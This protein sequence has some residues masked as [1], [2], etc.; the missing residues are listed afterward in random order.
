[1]DQVS[2]FSMVDINKDERFLCIVKDDKIMNLSYEEIFNADLYD[3]LYAITYVSSPSFF[4]KVV[5]DF[6]RVKIVLGID[7]PELLENF[8]NGLSEL[9][10]IKKRTNFWNELNTDIKEKM[11]DD[12]I[13]IRFYSKNPIHSKIYLL[14]NSETKNNRVIIGSANLTEAAFA[15]KNQYEDIIIFDNDEKKFD[16]YFNYRFKNIFENSI[17]YIPEKVRK[18][19]IK[20]STVVLLDKETAT[21]LLNADLENNRLK[22][23][24][25][26]EKQIEKL[27]NRPQEIVEKF[28]LKKDEVVRSTS[29][30]N[31]VIKKKGYSYT[32]KPFVEL[33]KQKVH[34]ETLISKTSK[35]EEEEIRQFYKYWDKLDTII[36]VDK[37]N[38]DNYIPF[39]EKADINK[40]SK[41]LI[42]INKFIDA[43]KQFTFKP[44]IIY[45]S[46]IMEAILFSF[47]SPFMWK[48][49]EDIV[50]R[51]NAESN[52]STFPIILVLAGRAAS[53]K[54][55]VLEFIGMLL[56]N[57]SPFYIPYTSIQKGKTV[58]KNIMEGYFATEN[59]SPVLV[60]EI[61]PSFFTGRTGE[62]IIKD[63]SNNANGKHPVL[64]CTTNAREFNTNGQVLRRIY[65]IQVDSEFNLKELSTESKQY[66]NEI[67]SEIDC[68]LFKD[69]TYRVCQKIK[70]NEDYYR[71]NDCLYLARE[72]FKDYYNESNIEVPEWFPKQPFFDYEERGKTIWREL[73][74]N[75]K[76]SFKDKGDGT[77]YVDG[78]IFK[79]PKEKENCVNFLGYGCLKED[80]QIL[81]LDSDIFYKY[82]GV[83]PRKSIG[84]ILKRALKI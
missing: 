7:D 15:S 44:N 79:N 27:K 11:I 69:F 6:K 46:K 65:Y 8:T 78:V 84:K 50:L 83:K 16:I 17:D 75:Y 76:D 82:I 33:K 12:N 32:I 26:S 35:Q 3:E 68:S 25:L 14:K 38:H 23:Y 41:S 66:L 9:V 24:S 40:V 57:N 47:M 42:L 54:T 74:S 72:I 13:V 2:L 73:Y 45:Q 4:S 56:G 1:M 48:L 28:E 18:K 67:K 39:S 63:I 77:I 81:L 29:I 62:S 52:R 10:D 58:D 31:S 61:A 34:I 59:L 70:N 19:S 80:I 49:R 53:G 64:I 43:Y 36:M 20:D 30:I 37:N 5:K 21:E 71:E 55:S 22:I 51:T 60:D